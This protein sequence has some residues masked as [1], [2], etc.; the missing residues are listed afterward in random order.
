M[1]MV[2]IK[3]WIMCDILFCWMLLV[4]DD[5]DDELKRRR[6]KREN[7]TKKRNWLLSFPLL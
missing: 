5:D 3:N 1:M 7:L 6:G 2:E 4:D